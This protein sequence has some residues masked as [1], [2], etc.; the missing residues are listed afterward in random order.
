MRQL[1][2]A[3]VLAAI[4]ALQ[5]TAQDGKQT[6]ITGPHICCGNCEKSVAAILDKVE[7]V[8]DVKCDRKNKTVTFNAKNLKAAQ[9]ALAAM[10]E[11]G[12]AGT[13][14]Y[15]DTELTRSLSTDK[16]KSNEITV[17]GVHACC[18]MCHKA[19][20]KLFADAK[21]TFAGTGPQREVT[22]TGK[23][24]VANDVLLKLSEAGFNGTVEKK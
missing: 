12:F 24:L 7:G 4:C 9:A 16:T 8:A 14:K 22:I 15:G 6:V 1:L 11:G 23:D 3:A 19:I 18:G 20:Q 5:A 13:A 10:Y 17:K 2:T 21:V